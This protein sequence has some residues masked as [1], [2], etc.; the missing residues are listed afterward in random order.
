MRE[1][2]VPS[3]RRFLFVLEMIRSGSEMGFGI[4]LF[5]NQAPVALCAFPKATGLPQM[6]AVKSGDENFALMSR[7]E[8][9]EKCNGH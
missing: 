4:S 9:D 5:S 1:Q 6:N 7:F 3:S 8:D 2:G